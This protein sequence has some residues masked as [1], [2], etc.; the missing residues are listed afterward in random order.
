M[1]DSG[2]AVG[3][4]FLAA[5]GFASGNVLVRIGTQRVAAPAATFF[6][7]LTGALLVL[8]LAV[9]FNLHEIRT[10]QPINFVWFALMGTMA[11]PLARVLNNTAITMVGTSRATP[12]A[13]LQPI[14]A[15][16]LGMTLLGERPNLLVGLGAPTVV[17]GLVLV[18]MSSNLARSREQ[19]ITPRKLGY[20]LAAVGALTFASRDVIGRH[21]VSGMAPPLVTAAFALVIGGVILFGAVHRDVVNSLRYLPGRYVIICCLAGI[22]QGIA[23]SSLF[24]ALSKAPV[25]VVS[26]INA[27]SALITLALSHVFLRRMESINLLLVLGT[28]ISVGGV[29]MVVLGA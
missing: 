1:S 23:I 3:L 5:T 6:T 25:T 15:L 12:M 17:S 2:L 21:V 27:S 13:S 29:I 20:L 18:I 11:Y 28:I 10:L 26:P 14:F 7:V 4:A 8:G 16:G 19:A 24:L 9:A 22:F